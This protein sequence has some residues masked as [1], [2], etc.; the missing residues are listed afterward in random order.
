MITSLRFVAPYAVCLLLGL[1]IGWQVQA[2]RYGAKISAINEAHAVATAKA[3]TA[4]QQET[5]RLQGRIAEIDTAKTKELDHAREDNRR[6]GAAVADGSRRLRIATQPRPACVPGTASGAGVDPAPSAELGA[7]A[8]QAYFDL[9]AGL[10]EQHAQLEACQRV[11]LKLA[12]RSG[13][14]K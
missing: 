13:A 3:A 5:A 7:S 12:P 4:A 9:R 11:L 10:I 1:A 2:W 6:L 14:I 8:R